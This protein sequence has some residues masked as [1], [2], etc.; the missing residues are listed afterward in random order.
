M[1]LDKRRSL[2]LS[3]TNGDAVLWPAEEVL[4]NRVSHV[5]RAEQQD[6]PERRR[7]K[8]KGKEESG[9]PRG[10]NPAVVFG[11]SNPPSESKGRK[12]TW[13]KRESIDRSG[14]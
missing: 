2:S 4:H 11:C 10:Y 12:S 14:G 1:K 13:I 9:R 5:P 8:R 6:F 3:L 7:G